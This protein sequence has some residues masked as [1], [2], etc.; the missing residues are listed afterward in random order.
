MRTYVIGVMI[1]FL[2]FVGGGCDNVK[3]ENPE[4]NGHS[5][6]GGSC[7]KV[8]CKANLQEARTAF[9]NGDYEAAFAQYRCGDTVEAAAGA[10]LTR[11][12]LIMQSD[13]VSDIL[14]DFGS[15][16]PFSATDIM[17]KNGIL[18]QLGSYND[19]SSS[20]EIPNRTFTNIPA[21]IEID[22]SD[23]PASSSSVDG[24]SGA[25]S[26]VIHADKTT[27]S[28]EVSF[29]M[30]ILP[31]LQLQAGDTIAVEMTCDADSN[32]ADV[33]VNPLL[34]SLNVSLEIETEG[35]YIDCSLFSYFSN[36]D[37]CPSRAGAID[38]VKMGAPNE[39]VELRF[40][41]IPLRCY[42][43]SE[44]QELVFFSGTVNGAL[45]ADDFE[46]AHMHP[47]FNDPESEFEAIPDGLTVN[48][49]IA[50]MAPLKDAFTEAACYAAMADNGSKG[51]V[52]MIPKEL[53]GTKELPVTTR[54]T[55]LMAVLFY[56]AAAAI[57]IA[58]SYDVP[59]RLGLMDDMS[60]GEI[61]EEINA[62]IG[63]L[64]S[65][66]QMAGALASMQ[67]AAA[68]LA[69]AINAKED[70]GLLRSNTYTA[71]LEPLLLEYAQF[72]LTSLSNGLTPFPKT[73]PP[74][75]MNLKALFTNPPDPSKISS[76]M[77]VV[78]TEDWDGEY[79][80]GVEQFFKELLVNAV[81]DFD[82]DMDER[83]WGEDAW[84]MHGEDAEEWYFATCEF[85]GC[86]GYYEEPSLI[87]ISSGDSNSAANEDD[88]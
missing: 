60:T 45:K 87:G 5:I 80:E 76:D 6:A 37:E 57:Q 47:L 88:F 48:Q 84:E 43:D 70:V 20:F 17:G 63:S 15:D 33:S 22:T 65:N 28:Q 2:L 67:M 40:T 82:Y 83:D 77:L 7:G 69:G 24:P 29:R 64:K 85:F 78:E 58:G 41:D 59:I 26:I 81:P 30:T 86:G 46:T 12:A 68:Q 51:A 19:G 71:G 14:K 72:F 54:D 23:Y 31:Q 18:F 9:I 49:L 13:A 42:T 56:G 35:E 39:P 8:S 61:A 44:V 66:H 36:P 3:D 73:N 34:D 10:A 21:R 4:G 53:A 50:H 75:M 1:F 27:R 16:T 62:N 79:V 32:R 11:L 55:K 38:V 25:D 52:Y 74:V